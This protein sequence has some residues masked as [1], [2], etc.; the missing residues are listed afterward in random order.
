MLEDPPIYWGS[1]RHKAWD[2]PDGILWKEATDKEYFILEVTKTCWIK[3]QDQRHPSSRVRAQLT[4][5]GSS[6]WSTNIEFSKSIVLELWLRGIFK[7]RTMTFLSLCPYSFSHHYS[8][9]TRYHSCS[10]FLS[11][12][13]RCS[14]CVH[15]RISTFIRAS[16]H[17]SNTRMSSGNPLAQLKTDE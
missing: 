13:L 9:G 6:N 8:P 15:Q 16:L 1:V 11:V 5:N 10:W 7:R 17:E 12:W 14:M 3:I 4:F 2:S